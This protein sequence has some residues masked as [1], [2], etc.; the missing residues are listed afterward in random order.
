M[1]LYF[2]LRDRDF[3]RRASAFSR[4]DRQFAFAHNFKP[5]SDIVQSDMRVARVGQSASGLPPGYRGTGD[6]HFVCERLL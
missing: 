1:F 5:L 2:R 3:H 6:E 4:G